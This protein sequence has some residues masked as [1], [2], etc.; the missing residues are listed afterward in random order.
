VRRAGK[1]G[2]P[3]I[4]VGPEGAGKENTA[5]EFA[6]LLN[7]AAPDSC[8]PAKLCE[9]CV[10]ALSFQHP[11]IRWI[12]PAPASL[13]DAGVRDL[14][15]AK[16]ANPFHQDPAAATALVRIGDPENPEPMTIRSLIHFLRRRA[17]QSPFKVAVIADGHRMNA[18]AANAFLKTLEEPPPNTVIFLLST[19]TE[20]MLPTILSRCQKI[21]FEPW[22]E[23]ELAGLLVDIAGADP[24]AAASAARTAEGN[25]RRGLALLEDQAGLMLE[26]ASHLFAW[27]HEGDRAMAAIAADELHRGLLCHRCRPATGA[28]KKAADSGPVRRDRAIQLCELLNL[29]YSDALFALELGDAQRPRLPG[30]KDLTD[31]AAAVRSTGSLLEDIRRIDAAR[32]EIDRNINIGLAMAVLFEGLID[33]AERDK[34]ARAARA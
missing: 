33:H 34:A 23:D 32:G 8:R 1:L 31:R 6:R 4:L 26:W 17:F 28:G 14:L 30:A 22:S 27:I 21:R 24:A 16:I 9:S 10:K 5:L 15:D 19:G 3:F 7:C 29:H 13:D 2:Q 20:G 11:D 12:G 25:A 18:A